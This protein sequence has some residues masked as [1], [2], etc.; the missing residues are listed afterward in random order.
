MLSLSFAI[1]KAFFSERTGCVLP[2]IMVFEKQEV[3][4]KSSNMI[5]PDRILY[6]LN[7]FSAYNNLEKEP[8]NGKKS[9][10]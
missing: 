3:Q 5:N 1:S 4:M 2:T 9:R 10:T 8:G 6:Y 7:Y